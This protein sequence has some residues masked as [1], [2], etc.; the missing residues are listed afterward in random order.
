M[1]TIPV[2]VIAASIA[3]NAAS[4]ANA[5][6]FDQRSGQWNLRPQPSLVF[7]PATGQWEPAPPDTVL[8]YDPS[9][10]QWALGRQPDA[11]FDPQSG[12][13]AEPEIGDAPP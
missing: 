11:M 3:A 8:Q 13:W 4:S 5:Q 10:G 7:D 2:L 1:R 12:N 6:A 9:T